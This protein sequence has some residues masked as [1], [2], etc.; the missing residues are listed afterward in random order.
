VG[1]RGMSSGEISA[2]AY[3][4][5]GRRG[6]CG[7]EAAGRGRKEGLASRSGR[8]I[9]PPG[10]LSMRGS[11]ANRAAYC[12]AIRWRE[13]GNWGKLNGGRAGR[14]PRAARSHPRHVSRGYLLGGVL[15]VVLFATRLQL[16][17]CRMG[18]P[19]P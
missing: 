7:V 4:K 12:S 9:F 18:G 8:C 17:L 13:E 10:W 2:A 6:R 3:S 1:R 14:R 19:P 15:R 16:G 11:S 5:G